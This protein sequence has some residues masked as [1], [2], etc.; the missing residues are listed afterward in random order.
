[1]LAVCLA[2]VALCVFARSFSLPTQGWS[3]ELLQ[4]IITEQPCVHCQGA[5]AGFA[6]FLAAFMAPQ[7]PPVQK[8]GAE[9]A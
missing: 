4:G 9:F 1:M 7:N 6:P 3:A 5:R 2:A 8:P